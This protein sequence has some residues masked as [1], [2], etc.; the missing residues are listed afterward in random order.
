MLP[1]HYLYLGWGI[2]SLIIILSLLPGSSMP[3]YNWMQLLAIDKWGHFIF[4][5]LAAW[6]FKKYFEYQSIDRIQFYIGLSLLSL[7]ILLEFLQ[8]MMRQG[9]NFDGLDVVADALG[10]ICGLKFFDSLFR[11][12]FRK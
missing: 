9:R 6:C 2:V 12:V 3:K 11:L 10:I 7:G 4:Y 5:G 8:L 1:R